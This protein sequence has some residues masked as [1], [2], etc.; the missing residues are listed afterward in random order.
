MRSGW[1][2]LFRKIRDSLVFQNAE[3]LKLWILCLVNANHQD[4]LVRVDGLADP[5]LVKR[6]QFITGRYA[7]HSEYYRAKRKSNK[8]PS[9][10]WRWLESLQDMENLHI[11]TNSRFSLITIVNYEI[12]QG[13]D[14]QNEQA[15]EQPVNSPCTAGEQPVRT[16]N[17][18]NNENNDNKSSSSPKL[19]FDEADMGTARW[20][21]SLIQ[22]D[23]PN[24][25]A[26]N[27]EKWA[28][29]IRLMRE[30]DQRTPE[31][32]RDVF[33]WANGD[34]FWKSNV[35]SPAK[36]REKFSKLILQMKE[37]KNGNGKSYT[38]GPGQQYD[39]SAKPVE[40]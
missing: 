29:E 16:N 40:W 20:M 30:H 25:R 19:R 35:L 37:R 9:T 23:L 1:V 5:V 17:N 38:P 28:N 31:A 7:L 24:E 10:L 36:L 12:Y 14:F 33:A 13:I 22:R 8:S 2:C 4:A 21:F 6:G 27:F 26:P 18:V 39:P 15:N 11:E 3:L 32:I 34:G